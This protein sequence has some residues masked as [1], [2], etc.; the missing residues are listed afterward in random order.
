MWRARG[1]FHWSIGLFIVVIIAFVAMLLAPVIGELRKPAP[2]RTSDQFLRA[3]IAGEYDEAKKLTDFQH[4]P[5]ERRNFV[6]AWK[7]RLQLWD[8]VEGVEL[9]DAVS[10]PKELEH[11][12]ASEGWRVEYH[13]KGYL[14]VGYVSI[15]VVPEGNEWKVVD[16][17]FR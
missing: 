4:L 15:Y 12:S 9:I 14:S 5:E 1:K 13:I 10:N 6:E 7:D 16:Y 8:K 2:V 11:P 17:V 3:L